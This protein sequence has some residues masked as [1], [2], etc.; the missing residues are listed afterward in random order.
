MKINIVEKV[1]KVLYSTFKARLWKL[2]IRAPK[3]FR[4]CYK[5]KNSNLVLFRTLRDNKTHTLHGGAMHTHK[6]IQYKDFDC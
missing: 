5:P 6:Y 2:I 3:G 4:Y 1:I